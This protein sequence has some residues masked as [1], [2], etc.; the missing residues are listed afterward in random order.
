M[1]Q[2]DSVTGGQLSRAVSYTRNRPR[3]PLWDDAVL[4]RSKSDRFSRDRSSASGGLY[5]KNRNDPKQT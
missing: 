1:N 2:K 3:R 4:R 5:S